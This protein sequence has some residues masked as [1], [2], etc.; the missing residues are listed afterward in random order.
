MLLFRSDLLVVGRVV[1]WESGKGRRLVFWK[2]AN[3]W[4]VE[5][6]QV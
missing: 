4:R 2:R 6:W 5:R 3:G 1:S